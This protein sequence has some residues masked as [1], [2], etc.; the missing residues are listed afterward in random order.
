MQLPPDSPVRIE[1]AQQAYQAFK[2]YLM[3]SD[4][5]RFDAAFFTETVLMLW[6]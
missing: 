4:P 5:T 6:P 3:M 2:A 1:K